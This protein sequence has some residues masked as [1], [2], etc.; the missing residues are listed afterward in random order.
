[1]E[2]EVNEAE[3]VLH[4][5]ALVDRAAL[6]LNRER[7][8]GASPAAPSQRR[9]LALLGAHGA[10]TQQRLLDELELAPASLSEVVGKLEGKGLVARER[11]EQDRRIMLVMLTEKG[12][13]C[14]EEILVE[15]ANAAREAFAQ[16]SDEEEGQLKALLERI[17]APRLLR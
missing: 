14:A 9:V 8:G 12:R 6:A 11:L 1:M 16:L 7:A 3:R 15:E 17:V 10:L 2:T 4:L 13:S 5:K